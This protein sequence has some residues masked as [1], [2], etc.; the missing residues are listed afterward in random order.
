MQSSTGFESVPFTPGPAAGSKARILL[1][2]FYGG[3]D[4]GMAGRLA[5]AQLVKALPSQR[6]LTFDN[7]AL[8]DYRSHRPIL[9]ID[10]WVSTSMD[11]PEVVIDLVHDDA[12]TPVW[13]LHGPEPDFR[14]EA[15]AHTVADLAHD[16]GIELTAAMHGMPSG[17]PHTRPVQVHAHATDAA[18][19]PE[20]PQMPSSMQ[21]TTTM[22][23]F[24]HMR[25]HQN[26]IEGISLL[27]TVPYYLIEHPYPPA[28]SVMLS[29]LSDIAGL[30]LPVGD[31]EQGSA[32]DLAAIEALVENNPDVAS[33]IAT[34]EQGY[35][36]LD[37][38]GKLPHIDREWPNGS[39][40]DAALTNVQ[41]AGVSD[42]IE[43]FLQNM[44]RLEEGTNAS[45]PPVHEETPAPSPMDTLE[46]VLRR[47][48]EREERRRAGLPPLARQPL[49]RAEP[50]PHKQTDEVSETD[51]GASDPS[52]PT[53]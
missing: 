4:A 38:M 17:V 46:D 32:D 31:L 30:A 51:A 24:L 41:V 27:P 45:P 8:L 33:A 15:F 3:M 21:V 53:S 39:L 16:A 28:A 18:L 5:V 12:G 22:A 42:S 11:I 14:W 40:D 44:T 2:H 23:G 43:A 36:A 29:R 1:T 47:I 25:M 20:Q 49:R 50:S 9:T 26:G 6:V 7:D 37:M 10:E 48:E 19:L 13:I 35:D 34:M 52:H